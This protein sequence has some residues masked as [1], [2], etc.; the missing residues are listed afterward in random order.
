VPP[1]CHTQTCARALR[2]TIEIEAAHCDRLVDER[3]T[4]KPSDRGARPVESFTD[5]SFG[6]HVLRAKKHVERWRLALEQIKRKLSMKNGEVPAE[7]DVLA[8]PRFAYLRNK[9]RD[10]LVALEQRNERAL[11]GY[12]DARRSAATLIGEDGR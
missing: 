2:S 1:A 4:N 3:A 12:E 9:T 10:E 7:G 11:K 5:C 6:G 8:S